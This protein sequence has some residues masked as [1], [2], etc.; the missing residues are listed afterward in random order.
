MYAD[1]FNRL[2]SHVT[3]RAMLTAAI[4]I[5]IAS[6]AGWTLPSRVAVLGFPL[7]VVAAYAGQY[8]GMAQP[9]LCWQACWR[10]EFAVKANVATFPVT[11]ALSYLFIHF[12]AK[13][14]H[15]LFGFPSHVEPDSPR[16]QRPAG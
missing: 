5:L 11:A 2:F 3:E 8:L 9:F 13:L 1:L 4:G 14:T 6:K 15:E 12:A 16:A 10:W 7:S